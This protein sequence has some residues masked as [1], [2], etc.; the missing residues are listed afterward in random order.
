M[1]SKINDKPWRPYG[2]V[3]GSD[4]QTR[5]GNQSLPLRPCMRH[6]CTLANSDFQEG[7]QLSRPS[8]VTD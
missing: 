2:V 5:W 6:W 1:S 8:P 3:T 4:S 7:S